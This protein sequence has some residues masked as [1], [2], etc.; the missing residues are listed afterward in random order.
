MRVYGP[1]RASVGPE[2]GYWFLGSGF[3][4]LKPEKLISEA[5]SYSY[6]CHPIQMYRP[7]WRPKS[8]YKLHISLKSHIQMSGQLVEAIYG[9]LRRVW[10]GHIGPDIFDRCQIRAFGRVGCL[11]CVHMPRKPPHSTYHPKNLGSQNIM[12]GELKASIWASFIE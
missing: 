2:V 8:T 6:Q 9:L 4:I 3:H 1:Y 5:K 12:F 11:G 10:A 7:I